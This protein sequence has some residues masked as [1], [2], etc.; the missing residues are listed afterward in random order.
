[1]ARHFEFPPPQE[2]AAGV[3]TT[4]DEPAGVAVPLNAPGSAAEAPATT[5]DDGV[6]EGTAV[7]AVAVPLR[8]EMTG[9]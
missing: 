4:V 7:T 5:E 2:P 6:A 9:G 8:A 1:M 3:G